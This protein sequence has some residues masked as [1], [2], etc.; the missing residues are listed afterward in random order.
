[1][2]EEIIIILFLF[3]LF[4]CIFFHINITTVKNRKITNNNRKK[5]YNSHIYTFQCFLLISFHS[6][7]RLHSHLVALDLERTSN[8]TTR[9]PSDSEVYSLTWHAIRHQINSVSSWARR[10]DMSLWCCLL[11]MCIQS[12]SQSISRHSFIHSA[13]TTNKTRSKVKILMLLCIW[14]DI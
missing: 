9:Q 13:S 1:M 2:R 7:I 8:T 3:L 14:I 12:V 10:N 4:Q 11:I 6:F 5:L